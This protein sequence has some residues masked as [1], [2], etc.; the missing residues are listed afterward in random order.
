M[1]G[2]VRPCLLS[3]VAPL[4]VVTQFYRAPEILLGI[5]LY[6]APVDM[7]SVGCIFAE[8]V[9]GTP[10]FMG[11]SEVGPQL[12]ALI[13]LV[14]RPTLLGFSSQLWEARQQLPG[15]LQRGAVLT[16]IQCSI[17]RTVQCLRTACLLVQIGQLYR[18]FQVLGTPSAAVWPTVEEL[19]AWQPGFPQWGPRDLAEV[20]TAVP[21]ICRRAL[22]SLGI[23]ITA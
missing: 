1:F 4:Q 6:G 10:L 7:W 11:D 16:V 15:S 2:R 18:I 13:L 23:Y 19:P 17:H 22:L 9:L 21:D 8:L 5:N 14:L 12:Q 20:C 3:A